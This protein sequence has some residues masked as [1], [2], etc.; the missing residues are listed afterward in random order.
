MLDKKYES[1]IEDP[2]VLLQ[3]R[4]TFPVE[5]VHTAS[6]I[7]HTFPN[8]FKPNPP[9][10]YVPQQV[11][12]LIKEKQNV[13]VKGV[14]TPVDYRYVLE[15]KVACVDA[16]NRTIL[17]ADM[18]KRLSSQ[19]ATGFYNIDSINYIKHYLMQELR[20]LAIEV[21]TDFFNGPEVLPDDM[22]PEEIE[23]LETITGLEL[24][25]QIHALNT[26]VR[27]EPERIYFVRNTYNRLVIEKCGDIRAY[28]WLQEQWD[29]REEQRQLEEGH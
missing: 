5:V 20:N 22:T 10:L 23:R 17:T 16:M 18:A 15:H 29:K 7:V 2:Q 13:W 11:M 19:S 4:E 26:F 1:L 27:D 28:L 8:Y 3:P 25:D 14:A 21:K 24:C 6:E 12:P 9:G